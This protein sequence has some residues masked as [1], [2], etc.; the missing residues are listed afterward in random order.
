VDLNKEIKLS[1]LFRRPKKAKK[2]AKTSVSSSKRTK[3]R[4]PRKHEVVGLKVGASQIAASRVINNG[5]TV[6][7]V[8]QLARQ[9][10]ELGVVVGGEVRDVSALARVLDQFFTAHELPRRGIRLGIGTNQIGVRALDVDGIEDEDQLENAVRFRAHEALAIPID[11]A[12]LDYHVVRETVDESGSISRRVLLAA[13]YR[14]PIDQYIQ[15]FREAGLELEGIDV[16]AFALLRA[17]APERA[18]VNGDKPSAIVA[19]SLGHDRSTLAIS[20]GKVCD[21]VRVLPWGG[22]KLEA[23][24]AR[25]LALSPDEAAELKRAVSLAADADP[26]DDLDDPRLPRAREAV[27][28]EVHS[29]ARE[30]VASLQ[31]YQGQPESLAIAEILVT[32]GTTQLPGL[33]EELERLVRARVRVADPLAHV[34]VATTVSSRDDLASLAVAIGL[35]VDS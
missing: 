24:I 34:E 20:D 9:P 29:L 3:G 8:V 12:V 19:L 7:R 4:K 30:I 1:D 35:G 13:A 28:R 5:G 21:F 18:A 33:A 15:A 26:F 14:E 16:E 6:P 25:D 27:S 23:V 22:A 31:F 10:L 32:G 11:Q 2:P 17:V